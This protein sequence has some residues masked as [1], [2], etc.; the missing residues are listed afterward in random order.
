M[1]LKYNSIVNRIV[2]KCKAFPVGRRFGKD[3]NGKTFTV[4]DKCGAALKKFNFFDEVKP[5]KKAEP[6]KEEFG[7]LE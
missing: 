6:K 3:D 4:D 5:K 2:G 7:G 1:E